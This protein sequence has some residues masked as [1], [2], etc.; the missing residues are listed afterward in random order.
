MQCEFFSPNS[1]VNSLMWILGG[2]FLGGEFLR[3]LFLLENIG[4][5]NSTPEFGPKIRGWKIRIPEFDP[6]FGFRRRKIP[7]AE[8]WTWKE[9]WNRGG[10]KRAELKLFSMGGLLER[11]CLPPSFF[12]PPPPRLAFSENP[13]GP[14]IEKIQDRQISISTPSK[15]L[16]FVGNSEGEDWNF[17]SRLKFS[18]EIEIFNR[19]WIFSIFGPLGKSC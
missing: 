15:P 14:K 7:S 3:G 16:F 5:K 8:T 12:L 4:P 6:K 13:K 11:L 18:S 2:E 19:D 10:P 17:Q 1:G 9:K